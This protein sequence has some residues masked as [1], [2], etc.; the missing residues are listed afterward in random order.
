MS[1]TLYVNNFMT[2]ENGEKYLRNS[3]NEN[4]SQN[5]IFNNSIFKV[6][7]HRQ[8]L[9]TQRIVFRSTL[10]METS[11]IQASDNQPERHQHKDCL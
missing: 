9:S 11:G 6:Q 1:L 7:G 2:E 3:R 5:F 8:M 4:M 10:P